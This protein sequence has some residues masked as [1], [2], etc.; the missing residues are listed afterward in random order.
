M[1]P[2][3]RSTIFLPIAKPIPMPANCFGC[4]SRWNMP[5]IFSKCSANA[6][7]IGIGLA[8]ISSTA[9]PPRSSLVARREMRTFHDD[10]PTRLL[11]E[12]DV[13]HQGRIVPGD[14]LFSRGGRDIGTDPCQQLP[15]FKARG[16]EISQQ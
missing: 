4:G 1:P 3:W 2:P 5:R 8:S 10:R 14:L 15:N 13:A 12:I 11:D 9:D 6:R 7:L 16:R